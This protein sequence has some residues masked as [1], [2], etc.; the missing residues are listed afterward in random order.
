MRAL[1]TGPGSREGRDHG[2]GRCSLA[3]AI[4][5]AEAPSSWVAS[6]STWASAAAPSQGPTRAGRPAWGWC[7]S[8]S[9][10]LQTWGALLG[11]QA[12]PQPSITSRAP[13][14]SVVPPPPPRAGDAHTCPPDAGRSPDTESGPARAGRRHRG[15][16][17]LPRSFPSCCPEGRLEQTRCRELLPG[18]VHTQKGS[19]E[20]KR[21]RVIPEQK[22]GPGCRPLG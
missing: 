5:G 17:A 15:P 19:D 7:H 16:R 6:W 8:E 2:L 4:L 20:K 9:A 1:E 12:D 18:N 11:F 3:G 10:P 14:R 13:T 22:P 21:H